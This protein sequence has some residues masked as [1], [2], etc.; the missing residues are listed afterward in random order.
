MREK[1]TP[2][3]SYKRVQR[4]RLIFDRNNDNRIEPAGRMLTLPERLNTGGGQ[5]IYRI[6][7]IARKE[8]D[9]FTA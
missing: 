5:G 3:C 2:V 9:Y 1:H 7:R 8:Y 6:D 4:S